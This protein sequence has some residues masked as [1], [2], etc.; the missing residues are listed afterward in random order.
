[1]AMHADGSATGNS[2]VLEKSVN[3]LWGFQY[4]MMCM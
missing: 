3:I 1:V 4:R 2:W